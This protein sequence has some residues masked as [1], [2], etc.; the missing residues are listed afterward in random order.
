MSQPRKPECSLF[1]PL[2]INNKAKNVQWNKKIPGSCLIH[3]LQS[4]LT[5]FVLERV[6]F[7]DLGGGCS[8]VSSVPRLLF[9]NLAAAASTLRSGSLNPK[10]SAAFLGL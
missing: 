4:H 3:L 9:A 1:I 5:Y 10:A 2:D 6:V 8:A 7:R